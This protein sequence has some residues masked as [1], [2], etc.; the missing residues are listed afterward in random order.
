LALAYAGKGEA[1]AARDYYA[2]A[3]AWDESH[4]NRTP[5]SSLD[6]FS[7]LFEEARSAIVP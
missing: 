4:R 7:R 6:E 2:K 5:A 1:I 3:K